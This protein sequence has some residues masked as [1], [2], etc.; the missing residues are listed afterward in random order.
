MSVEIH[1]KIIYVIFLSVLIFSPLAFGTV[2]T[3][4]Y[5]V[6]EGLIFLSFSLFLLK[7]LQH[8]EEFVYEVPGIIPLL[9]LTGYIFIQIIP[10]PPKLVKF[11][12]PETYNLYEDTILIFN[13]SSWIS[14]SINK[15]ATLLQFFKISSYVCFYFITIQL[16]KDQDNLKKTVAVIVIFASLLSFLSLLQ[17]IVSNN[18]IYWIRKLTQGGTPFGPYVNRNHYAGL[19]EMIFPIVLSLF[20]LYKP[21]VFHKSLREKFV[22]IFNIN[23]TNIYIL[24]G[25]AAVLIATSVF[26]TLS[27][28]GIVSLCLSM[29]VFGFLFLSKG[30][31]KK[32]GIIIITIFILI[33]LSVGW[34]GWEPI[35]ERF[36]KVR[37]LEG[38]ISDLRI[39][40]WRDS[41]NIIEDFFLTG[42]GAGTFAYIY[43][44]YKTISGSAVVDH[45]HNDY[46][47][48]LSEGGII[49]FLLC[50]WFLLVVLYKT[51]ISFRKRREL[52]SIYIVIAALTGLI[53]ILIHS[54]TDFN[55][56]IGANGLYFFA[57]I[58][59]AVSAANTRMRE[60]FG[61]TYLKKIKLPIKFLILPTTGLLFVSFI[62]NGG[63]LISSAYFSSINKQKLNE[64]SS[65][66]ELLSIRE[67][68]Y[69]ASVFDPLEAK[70][71]YAIANVEKLLSNNMGSIEYYKKSVQLNPVNPEYLQRLGL[72]MYE[73]RMYDV[74]DKLFISSIKYD[75]K[76][77][78]IY[79]RYALWLINTD[80]REEGQKFMKEAILLEP[81]KTR[82]YITLMVLSGFSDEEILKLLPEKVQPHLIFAGYL[83]KTGRDDLAEN[84]YLRA[85]NYIKNEDKIQP[86]I[87]KDIYRYYVKRGK[88][89]DAIEIVKKGLVLIPDDEGL[90]MNLAY[91][92]EKLDK[93]AIAAEQYKKVLS[94]NP[95]NKEAKKRL[96]NLL[97]KI[98]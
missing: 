20:L 39:E 69:K 64:I 4:S 49:I 18:K 95:Q 42:T 27:R 48:I 80:K 43:P 65:K 73:S 52:Y 28:S 40:I 59:L 77:A 76:N 33:V 29:I 37:T 9:L 97:L 56:D 82:E 89:E 46:I 93:N 36:E 58:A 70:Y 88:Y 62:Y 60:G 16:L 72:L 92:Y 3:W 45:A 90:M 10:L 47:E 54:I 61:N 26:L 68:A 74:A 71:K 78:S 51:Y 5:A 13:P 98:Q 79:K 87:F 85:L 17:H 31:N 25:F 67:T 2:E 32:T 53:A 15:K 83:S 34:F 66:E 8:N 84:V 81:G 22:R 44:K 14:I 12:A 7:K 21:H 75:P 50:T 63:I 38:N 24:L 57:I 41:K 6:L 94:V 35:F 1:N 19:M 96:E 30:N 23:K 11:I 55:L 86:S 91:L